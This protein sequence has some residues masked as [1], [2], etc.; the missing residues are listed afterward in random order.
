M[1]DDDTKPTPPVKP[2]ARARPRPVKFKVRKNVPGLDTHPILFSSENE[3]AAKR[4]ITTSYPRGREVY[5][6][7]PDGTRTHYSAD[8]AFQGDNPWLPFEDEDED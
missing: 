3:N 7:A 8:H 6:E 1:T 5:L 4:H 2:A